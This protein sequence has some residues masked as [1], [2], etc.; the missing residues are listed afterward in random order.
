MVR[1]TSWFVLLLLI[2]GSLTEM[3][4]QGKKGATGDAPSQSAAASAPATAS[5]S[6][7]FESQ[8][9]S[10]DALDEI[11]DEITRQVCGA[12]ADTK[13]NLAAVAAPSAL[14]NTPT[15][16]IFDQATLAAIQQYQAFTANGKVVIGAYETLSSDPKQ[17]AT[18]LHTDYLQ[19]SSKYAAID[20]DKAK[21]LSSQW[22]KKANILAD[23]DATGP[24]FGDP[25]SD[26][27]SLLQALAASSNAQTPG[28]VAIPDS[29]MAVILTNHLKHAD[30]CKTKAIVYPPLFGAGS[31]TDTAAVDIQTDI[32]VVDDVRRKI[33][34]EVK[35]QNDAYKWKYFSSPASPEVPAA[36]STP[37]V[38]AKPATPGS[39]DT[40]L[41]AA[42]TDVD[43]LY[44]NFMN[45]LLQI[46][47]S[48]GVAGSAAV[49]QGKQLSRLISGI[50]D[51][52]GNYTTQPAYVLLATIVT[53]GGTTQ[54]HKTFWT[55]LS[56][57]DTFTY[58]G[59]AAVGVALW[60]V[61]DTSPVYA[62]V[63]RFKFPL[64]K[65][66]KASKDSDTASDSNLK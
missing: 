4:A 37:A 9:I 19:R 21:E 28:T 32:Q 57:G 17:L 16:V 61:T 26:F 22:S 1:V 51:T 38:P 58:N 50:K 63:L 45:S 35:D 27:T 7:A 56:T 43:G 20:T 42:L 54:D 44:D 46:N 30:G 24:A 8:M 53:A 49:I 52:A 64:E 10:F 47:S 41:T 31:E 34:G 62:D 6:A 59:G 65:F 25:V 36:G 3:R 48:T 60:R 14:G 66:K 29:A 13:R 15:I 18:S 39:G 11:A 5:S 12:T 55:E 33:H 2:I 23:V 40:V